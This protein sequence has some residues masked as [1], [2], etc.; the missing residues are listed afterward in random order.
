MRACVRARVCVCVRQCTGDCAR[1]RV[2]VCA[3][4]C[5]CVRACV[6]ANQME[7]GENNVLFNPLC[8]EMSHARHQAP[9]PGLSPRCN[10]SPMS[11]VIAAAKVGSPLPLIENLACMY[12]GTP[13]GS[14]GAAGFSTA[15]D[16]FA[17]GLPTRGGC[18]FSEDQVGPSPQ[19]GTADAEIKG[20]SK[21]RC[22]LVR[23][24]TKCAD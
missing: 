12:P 15:I 16:S 8:I 11:G 24:R 19:S 17:V 1:A 20:D 5:A 23:K 13:Y 18:V 7:K 6:R 21:R 2:C 4:A 3:R 14:A 9:V 10:A 22:D